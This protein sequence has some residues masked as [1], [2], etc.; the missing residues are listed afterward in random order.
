MRSCTIAVA[1]R[2][3]MVAEGIAAALDRFP[4]IVAVGVATT[5][6]AT[7]R[8]ATS[9]SAVALDRSLPGADRAAARLRGQG[10]RV[11]WLADHPVSE[12]VS[13]STSESVSELAIA[14]VPG[15][16]FVPPASPEL[17]SREL[18]VLRSAARGMAA[19]QIARELGISP[20]TV[21]RHKT[22]IFTKLGV[23][24]QTAAVGLATANGLLGG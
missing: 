17:T 2:E 7:E 20:K 23:P 12:D 16:T 21:E 8:L 22:R 5:A 14:L 15:L 6:S 10:V 11:V 1:H 4:L 9:A 3:A 19:Y 24:N 13:V 18:Q